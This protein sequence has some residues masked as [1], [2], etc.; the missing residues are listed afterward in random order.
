MAVDVWPGGCMAVAG[1]AVLKLVLDHEEGNVLRK[2]LH[3]PH[4]R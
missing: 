3:V 2:T 4:E 1:M